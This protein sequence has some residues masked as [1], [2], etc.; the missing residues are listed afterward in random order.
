M[1]LYRH[2]DLKKHV[3]IT[4]EKGLLLKSIL[5]FTF[6]IVIYYQ[7]NLILDIIS[8]VVVCIYS[9]VMNKE[10]LNSCFK[11]ILSKFKRA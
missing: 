9:F 8:L 1:L 3:N 10:F 5:I 4:F 11:T 7:R 2:F 6:A